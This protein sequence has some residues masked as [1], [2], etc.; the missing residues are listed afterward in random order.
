M[1]LYYHPE[2]NL[3]SVILP[4]EFTAD[5]NEIEQNVIPDVID[6]NPEKEPVEEY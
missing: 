6:Q 5:I 3:L 1:M 4:A 2:Q